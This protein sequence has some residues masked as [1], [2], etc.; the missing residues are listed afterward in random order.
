[1]QAQTIDQ[2]LARL[3]EILHDALVQSQRIGYFAGLYLRVT[4]SVKRAIV[5]GDVFQDNERMEQLDVTFAN[6]FLAAWDA[7]TSGGQ[8]TSPWQIAF[9]D[10]SRDD[11]M[12]VQHLAL[13]MNAHIDLDLGIATEEVMRQLGQPLDDIHDDFNMI[14]TILSRLIGIV[15]VQL[16]EISPTFA[17]IESLAPGLENRLFGDALK[18]LRDG[19]WE[20]ATRLDC[21]KT[22]AGRDLVIK[23]RELLADAAGKLIQ[24]AADLDIFAKFIQDV[25][26]EENANGIPFNIQIIAE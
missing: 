15:Q 23:D 10:L 1:M 13:G 19:A 21:R 17:K 8:P 3:T 22:A 18:G 14:N 7:W 5:A 9:D 12:V 4:W 24:D 26:A 16:A 6:R 20:L 25:V 2:V 11:L